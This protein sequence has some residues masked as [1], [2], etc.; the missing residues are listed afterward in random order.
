MKGL[1]YFSVGTADAVASIRL[2]RMEV[3]LHLVFVEKANK[4][5]YILLPFS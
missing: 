5:T 4:I 2:L 3:Q 1:D